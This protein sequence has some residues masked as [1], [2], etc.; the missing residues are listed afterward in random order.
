MAPIPEPGR[1]ERR[2]LELRARILQA[3][4]WHFEEQGFHATTVATICERADVATKTFFN[5]FETKQHLLREIARERLGVLLADIEAIC[6]NEET[7]RDRLLAFFDL[8]AKRTL[9]AGPMNREFL[10]ELVHVVNESPEKSDHARRLHGAFGA[11][12]EEGLAN[13]EVTTRHAPGTLTEMILG[14]YY[15]LMFN[16]ANLDAYPIEVHAEAVGHFL[17]DAIAPH[18]EE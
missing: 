18:P 12:V 3:A 16:Y 17:A 2:K 1:R 13:H 5:H 14:A 10:T 8:A 7:T 9:E 4:V 11:I 6:K 15:V